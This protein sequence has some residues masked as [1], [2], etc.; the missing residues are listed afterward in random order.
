MI[1]SDQDLRL[2]LAGGERV[3]TPLDDLDVQIQPASN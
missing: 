1:L 2:R 3:V